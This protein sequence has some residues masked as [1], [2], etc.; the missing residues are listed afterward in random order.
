M[1]SFRERMIAVQQQFAEAPAEAVAQA[2]LVVP[3]A[4]AALQG[5]LVKNAVDLGSWRQSEQPDSEELGSA[6]QRYQEYL[7]KV[8]PLS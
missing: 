1:L 4:V 7:D 5:I 8:P 6:L 2:E 3:D